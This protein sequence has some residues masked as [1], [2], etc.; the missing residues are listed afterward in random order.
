M[1]GNVN[2]GSLFTSKYH[3]KWIVVVDLI[4]SRKKEL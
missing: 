4:H 1:K 3:A 2:K